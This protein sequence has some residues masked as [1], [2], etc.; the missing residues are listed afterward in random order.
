M[1]TYVGSD[2]LE[3]NAAMLNKK[4]QS[5]DAKFA[6]IVIELIAPKLEEGNLS[7]LEGC[8]WGFTFSEDTVPVFLSARV[9]SDVQSG[10]QEVSVGP[11]VGV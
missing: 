4:L 1:R 6:R 11:Y 5:S 10:L 2:A 7:Y 9:D 8:G 3:F